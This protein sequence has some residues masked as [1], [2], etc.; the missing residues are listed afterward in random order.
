MNTLADRIR[1]LRRARRMTG[2]EFGAL[3]GVSKAYVSQLEKGVRTRLDPRKLRELA[4][5]LAVNPHWL[6]TGEGAPSSANEPVTYTREPP[7]AAEIMVREK[8]EKAQGTRI[9]ELERQVSQ[10]RCR[11]SALEQAIVRLTGKKE[12]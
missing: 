4:S 9:E 10:M 6:E 5:R 3:M 12:E 7:N 8:D 2:A 11:I 1:E